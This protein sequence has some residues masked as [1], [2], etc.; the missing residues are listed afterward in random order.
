MKK[1]LFV[2]LFVLSFGITNANPLPSPP[3][4]SEIYLDSANWFLELNFNSNNTFGDSIRIFSKTDTANLAINNWIGQVVILTQDSLLNTFQINRIGDIIEIQMYSP[5]NTWYTTDVVCWGNCTC[6]TY[7]KC[8]VNA[9]LSGQ[10][11]VMQEI[12]YG[13]S[14]VDYWLVKDNSPSLGTNIY[15]A[16]SRGTFCGYVNDH[17][18][19]PFSNIMLKYYNLAGQGIPPVFTNNSGYFNNDYIFARNYNITFWNYSSSNLLI[20][21]TISITIEPDSINYYEFILDT[22]LTGIE[23][24]ACKKEF[25]LS[26]FPNPTTGETTISFEIPTGVHYSKALLKMYNSNGEI[27]S[28]IPVSTSSKKEKYSVNWNMDTEIPSGMY[29]YKLELDGIKVASS[30]IILSK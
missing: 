24:T 4:I 15:Q 29:L 23:V 28:I 30:K 18:G 11:L 25:S 19:N 13:G 26:A 5:P 27:I 20:D 3:I 9:P 21:T 14:P 6:N 17:L 22:L 8:N 1:V 12:Q 2:V 16:T 7:Y 10:S